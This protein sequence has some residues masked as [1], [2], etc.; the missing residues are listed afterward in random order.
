MTKKKAPSVKKHVN[1]I[2][3]R[4]DLSL[5]QR[6][7]ANALLYHAYPHLPEKD[8]YEI[9]ISYLCGLIGFDSHNLEPLKE[10]IRGLI[11]VSIEW[12]VRGEAGLEVWGVF[13]ML[14]D[15]QIDAQSGICRYSYGALLRRKLYNPEIYA[16][17]N[18]DIQKN[19][20]ASTRSLYMKTVSATER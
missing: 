12:G 11:D 6:K 14:A 13:S 4:G 17:I 20:V 1:A 8:E 7:L 19:F 5:V 10:A 16:T 15:A 9:G 3:V 18:L 2:H